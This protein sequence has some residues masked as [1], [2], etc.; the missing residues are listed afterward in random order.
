MTVLQVITGG[1]CAIA[2]TLI[3]ELRKERF[4]SRGC[5]AFSKPLYLPISSSFH[6]N[7]YYNLQH[8]CTL[9]RIKVLRPF[10]SKL[11]ITI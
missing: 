3:V 11:K 7:I 2:F 9:G 5:E 10:R 8:S 4:Y 6:T 1:T